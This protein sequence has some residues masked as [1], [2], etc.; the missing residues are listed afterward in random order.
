M[1]DRYATDD[2]LATVWLVLHKLGSAWRT[3][4][5]PQR[6]ARPRCA[7]RPD[8]DADRDRLPGGTGRALTAPAKTF[9]LVVGNVELPGRWI[10]VGLEFVRLFA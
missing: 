10:C 3:N 8:G 1:P 4:P 5:R 7:G 2:A 6:V 9:R